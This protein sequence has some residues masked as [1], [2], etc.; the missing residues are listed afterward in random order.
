[1]KTEI[2]NTTGFHSCNKV[3]LLLLFIF[4]RF[5]DIFAQPSYP[6]SIN[7][8]VLWL[9]SDTN[10]TKTGNYISQWDDNS[11]SSNNAFQAGDTSLMP[12]FVDSFAL[13]NNFPVVRFTGQ[14]YMKFPLAA[15]TEYTVFSVISTGSE[16]Q[17]VEGYIATWTNIPSDNPGWFLGIGEGLYGNGT[18]AAGIGGDL[19]ISLGNSDHI[20]IDKFYI[21]T[22]TKDASQW[23]L[24]VNSS[25]IRNVPDNS[26]QTY[27]GT[28]NWTLGARDGYYYQGMMTGDIAIVLIYN[29]KL[30]PA[31]ILSIENYLRNKYAPPVEL[32]P[33][34]NIAYGFCDTVIHAGLNFISYRWYLNG[35]HLTPDTL[36]SF[37]VSYPGGWCKVEV[38]D[39]FG[40]TS[41]DSVYVSYPDLFLS[42]SDTT[43]CLYDSLL[44]TCT[45]SD[46]AGYTFLWSNGTTDSTTFIFE[47]S[48]VSVTVSDT[49]TCSS[50]ITSNTITV[51]IDSLPAKISLG[52]DKQICAGTNIS[53]AFYPENPS[54]LTFLWSDLSTTDSLFTV[55]QSGDFWVSVTNQNGCSGIDTV[56]ID[57]IGTAPFIDF[58]ADTVCNGLATVFNNFSTTVY[59]SLLWDFGDGFFSYDFSP[60]HVFNNSGDFLITLTLYSS[61]C[62]NYKQAWI[63]VKPKPVADFSFTSSCAGFPVEFTNL[64]Y[65]NGSGTITDYLWDFAGLGN[66]NTENSNFVFSAPGNYLV[67]LTITSS[68]G[69]SDSVSELINTVSSAPLSDINLSTPYNNSIVS[70]N[71]LHFTWFTDNSISNTLEVSLDNFNSVLF[72]K[73]TSQTFFDTTLNLTN[74]QIVYWRV[75]SFNYCYEDSTSEIWFFRYFNLS[76]I[77]GINLWLD[78]G[79]EIV[80]D[81]NNNVQ[82]WLNRV[83]NNDTAYQNSLTQRPLLIDS[84]PL[85]N[86]MP[87][88]RFDGANDILFNINDHTIGSAFVVSRWNG[89]ESVF[90]GYAGLFST[91]N[92][93]SNPHPYIFLGE[94]DSSNLYPSGVP[95]DS[96]FINDIPTKDYSPLDRYKIVHGRDPIPDIF[97]GFVAG[98]DLSNS[99]FWKGDIAEIIVFDTVLSEYNKNNINQYLRFKYAPP[100]ELGP[101]I[102]ISNSFC[103][104]SVSAYQLWFTSYVWKKDAS[105]DIISVDSVLS[106][107]DSGFYSVTVTDI[108]G[109]TST[110]SV[111]VSFT[112]QEPFFLADTAFCTGNGFEWDTGL[113]SQNY[114]FMWQDNSTNPSLFIDSPGEYSVTITDTKGCSVS[115][116]TITV[117]EDFF[118][119]TASLGPDTTLCSGNSISLQT[120][121][122]QAIEYLWSDSSSLSSLIIFT[123]GDYWVSVTNYNGCV[124]TD[125]IHID[126]SG[127][128]PVAGFSAANLC[129]G[130]ATVFTD[131]SYSPDGS[132]IVS[133]TW[134]IGNDTLYSPNISYV[135]ATVDTF[136]VKLLIE[137]ENSCSNYVTNQI[138]IRPL[139]N[140]NFTV[141]GKCERSNTLFTNNSTVSGGFPAN[142]LWNFGDNNISDNWEPSHTYDV[143]GNYTIKLFVETNFGCTDSSE[144]TIFIK[145]SPVALFDYSPA[146]SGKSTYFFDLSEI[147]PAL[148]VIEWLWDFGDGEN[149]AVPNPSH[150]Y[151]QPGQYFCTMY[152][153]SVNG[154]NDLAYSSLTVSNAPVAGFTGDSTCYGTPLMLQDTSSVLN[155]TIYQWQW[156]LGN[157]TS[158]NI[159]NPQV[160]YNSSGSYTIKLTVISDSDCKDSVSKQIIVHPLPLAGFEVSPAYSPPGSI[161][162]TINN[163]SQ[164]FYYWDF[165][166]GQSSQQVSPVISYSDT[167]IYTIWLKVT[168]THGCA[169]STRNDIRIVPLL[170]D[171]AVLSVNPEQFPG[172]LKVAALLSNMGTMP[173]IRPILMLYSNIHNPV[174]EIYDDTIFPGDFITYNLITMLP[175]VE[176]KIL[177]YICLKGILQDNAND[178]FPENN[179]SCKILVSNEVLLNIYPNPAFTDINIDL[180]IVQSGTAQI[181][182]FD[183]AGKLITLRDFSVNTGFN[184]LIVDVSTFSSGKYN[185]KISVPEGSQSAE[186]IKY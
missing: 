108:F 31:E 47:F 154:C 57:T 184:R 152:I 134:I 29:R 60:L 78:A 170:Y 38:T 92:I 99:P 23:E 83:N 91:N 127:V 77:T 65:E 166:N 54:Q 119:L 7:G 42:S 80:T 117:T 73:S 163:S 131:T 147:S 51:L 25:Y 76:N 63:N 59:D 178:A 130:Q 82:F 35:N 62:S 145:P 143:T 137:S 52:E 66:S 97:T 32:G 22:T 153:K 89:P 160:M 50:S 180:N 98:G 56:H 172:F 12:L 185:V 71:L 58:V 9:A 49:L 142:W 5:S 86:N 174:Y 179:E 103:D 186:F 116:D 11:T 93:A 132:N 138:I 146:C 95:W 70:D 94:K 4:M 126:I 109:F 168:D 158:S 169:D 164:G 173:V 14:Q 112:G 16:K 128:A 75:T 40:F 133:W 115:S 8:L 74:E 79:S 125:T 140:V 61:S 181:R 176:N 15:S 118:E 161:I 165:G 6:D 64:S 122:S 113:D 17:L 129:F 111:Y 13:L 39:I 26:S 102:Y 175:V 24:F 67:S 157:N 182:I 96:I 85:I 110:D 171:L 100:V 156:N 20:E 124:A 41:T 34:I 55:L 183:K 1:M 123:P 87:C 104:T 84:E 141:N 21:L 177:S 44:I 68:N 72:S 19:S 3:F 28:L 151:T 10:I 148:P 105:P 81:I 18:N 106:V 101:N 159:Q 150:I 107:S 88:L 36:E 45:L 53:L 155:G 121:V 69:C 149:A 114:S 43:I 30:I 144:E 37:T 33:G 120:G 162:T 27:S 136:Y 135:F 2:Q 139:P 90:P 167:G 48:S 46:S